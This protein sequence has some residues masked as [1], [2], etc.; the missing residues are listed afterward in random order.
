MLPNASPPFAPPKDWTG[1]VPS[2]EAINALL[3]RIGMDQVEW[4]RPRLRFKRR[5]M[6]LDLGG[7]GKEYA[8]DRLAEIARDLGIACG[9][10]DLG[11]DIRAIGAHPDGQPWQVNVRH[12]RATDT[13]MAVVPVSSGSLATSGDYE[14]F[15]LVDGVRYSHILNP[16]TGY[17]ARGLSS[18][19]VLAEQ[20]LVAGS[21]SSIAMLKGVEGPAWLASLGVKYLW[22]DEAGGSGGNVERAAG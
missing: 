8:V 22:M 13:A 6:E 20:C 15:M 19:S 10:V 17:P 3:P 7:I 14:R 18:V 2:T 21:L 11:R 12:A 4:Q 1:Q 9:L 16:R 5:G